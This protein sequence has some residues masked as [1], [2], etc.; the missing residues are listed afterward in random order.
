MAYAF[1]TYLSA[2][3][4]LLQFPNGKL[5]IGDELSDDITQRDDTD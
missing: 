1:A 3:D 4:V 2:G 5:L